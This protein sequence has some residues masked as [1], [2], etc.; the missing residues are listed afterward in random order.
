MRQALGWG[1]WLNLW[2]LIL[3]ATHA[4]I[5]TRGDGAWSDQYVLLPQASLI[6]AMRKCYYAGDS[7][8]EPFFSATK[9]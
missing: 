3:R 7:T 2:A 9:S 6:S 5:C 1:G 8:V 4:L